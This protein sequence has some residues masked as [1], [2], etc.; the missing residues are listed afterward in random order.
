MEWLFVNSYDLWDIATCC[1]VAF[2]IGN[3]YGR[4]VMMKAVKP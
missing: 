2:C 4:W 3:A 1:M